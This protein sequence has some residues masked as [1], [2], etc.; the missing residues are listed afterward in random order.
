MLLPAR[1]AAREAGRICS[2]RGSTND[3]TIFIE[4]RGPER[5]ARQVDLLSVPL[6]ISERKPTPT[7]LSQA[8]RSRKFFKFNPTSVNH[9]RVFSPYL[10]SVASYIPLSWIWT[11]KHRGLF[12]DSAIFFF[13]FF[14]P[15]FRA[16]HASLSTSEPSIYISK[17]IFCKIIF[18][19]LWRV[20]ERVA[21]NAVDLAGVKWLWSLAVESSRQNF[22]ITRG[23][24]S[25]YTTSCRISFL[26]PRR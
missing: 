21:I 9:V 4:S 6:E 16:E 11:K 18:S 1:T 3:G 22:N 15:T 20:T 14:R 10:F 23:V 26:T 5:R 19:R 25:E 24:N 17:R 2:W 13:F 7:K 8:E 12:T